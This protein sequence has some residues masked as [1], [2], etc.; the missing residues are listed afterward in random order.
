MKKGYTLPTG[1]M[2][3]RLVHLMD[4][5]RKE[6]MLI[7]SEPVPQGLS[8]ADLKQ[9]GKAYPQWPDIE[10]SLIERA[11]GSFQIH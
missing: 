9:G 3:V 1:M 8:V 6:L 10:K 4:D 2:S 5:A 7:Y 11:Q